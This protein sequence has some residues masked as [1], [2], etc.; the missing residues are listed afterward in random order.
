[1]RR[2]SERLLLVVNL[3]AANCVAGLWIATFLQPRLLGIDLDRIEIDRARAGAVLGDSLPGSGGGGGRA[4]LLSL[5]T[6]A[7]WLMFAIA[8]LLLLWNFS[9]LVRRRGDDRAVNSNWIVSETSAGPVRVARE[10]I[11]AGLQKAGES[12]PEVTRMR[13]AVALPTP[14]RVTVKG[15]FYCADGQ[16][17]LQASQR[18]RQVLLA[19]FGELVHLSDGMRAEFEL[20]FQ[21]FFGKLAKNAPEPEAPAPVPA[22][23]EEPFRGPQYPIDD[24][25]S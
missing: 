18:L 2:W 16:D 11:E 19:R 14:R 13:V 6:G 17:H 23:P 25:D 1:M 9:W 12:L 8:I 24:E 10:A 15:Q 5:D 21:G 4:M 20:E 22:E 3:T 7:A